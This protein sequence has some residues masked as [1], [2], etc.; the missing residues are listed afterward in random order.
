MVNAKAIGPS[1]IRFLA[2]ERPGAF[3]RADPPEEARAGIGGH[4]HGERIGSVC[5]HT[6]PARREAY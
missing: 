5:G 3:L 2:A 4:L 6:D 1:G